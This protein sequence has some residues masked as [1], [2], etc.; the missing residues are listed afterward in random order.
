MSAST[1][2]SGRAAEWGWNVLD[3]RFALIGPQ[4]VEPPPEAPGRFPSE[5]PLVSCAVLAVLLL[6]CLCPVLPK[7][8][9]YMDLAHASLPP[10]GAFWFGT[11]T[12][13]R[14]IFSMVWYGGRV[15]LSIGFL[16]AAV[17][18]LAGVLFGTASGLAPRWLDGLL[19]R[20]TEIL[21]SIPSLLL[22]LLLQGML[23]KANAVTIA[24]VI[25]AVSWTGI[26]KVVRTE[27]LQLRGSGYVAASR[28][29][30]GGF[31]HILR[32]HLAPNFLPSILF[33]VVMNLRS[34]ILME[35]T[36][37]FLGLGLPLEVISWGSMLSLAEK[38]LPGGAWWMILIPGGFLAAALLCITSIGNGLRRRMNRG[39]S[40]L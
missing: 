28:C 19:M 17:S 6:G 10:C 8:P 14:D 40:N 20:L 27:V 36:L 22:I 35:S 11:D 12:M 13:G 38:A 1:P 15:S 16:A 30:G 5:I 26:A 7:D 31:F 9:A 29:M 18:T 37:S 4:P 32:K 24:F 39:Q 33:M 2:E 21:L 23:G 3:E 34:A 25:G